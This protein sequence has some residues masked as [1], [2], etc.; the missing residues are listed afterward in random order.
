MCSEVSWL[1]GFINRFHV[2]RIPQKFQ[3]F[4]HSDQNSSVVQKTA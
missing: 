2:L 4:L 1:V 3:E